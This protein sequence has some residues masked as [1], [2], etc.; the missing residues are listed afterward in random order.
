MT[1]RWVKSGVLFGAPTPQPWARSHAALPV[2]SNVAESS[3][4]LHYSARDERNRAHIARGVVHADGSVL[5]IGEH[6]PEPVLAPGQLGAFDDCGVTSSCIVADGERRMLFYTGW[7]LARTVP[8]HFFIG[9]AISDDGGRSFARGSRAPVLGR[10]DIDPYLTASPSVLRDG[11][12]W[13]M[14]YVSCQRWGDSRGPGP[15]PRHYYHLRYAE[16]TDGIS[17]R[18]T[19]R[20]AIDF[21]DASE[22]AIARPQVRFE[23]GR[24][25]MWF[26]ARGASYRLGYAESRDGLTWERDDAALE[27]E[28][29]PAGWDSEMLAYPHVVDVAGHRHLLYNG[30]GYGRTGVGSAVAEP[31]P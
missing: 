28:P 29:G 31:A 10:S 13:R 23:E 6:D 22:Y 18:P 30:N 9:L 25:R 20:V 7:T 5:R 15:D 19:G 27:L 16:S 17:W 2:A 4:E 26:C 1:E 21:A 11:E 3:F 24:Y 12:A 14:W 8:F